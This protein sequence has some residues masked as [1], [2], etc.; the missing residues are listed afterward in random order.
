MHIQPKA[1]GR[2]PYRTV[3]VPVPLVA[4][5][6]ALVTDILY[7]RTSVL[8]W[9]N[10]SAWLLLGGLVFGALAILA[11]I[12]DLLRPN[13]KYYRP[14]WAGALCYAIVL[15]LGLLNSF[16]H[17]GDGWTAVVPG[18]LILSALT[19]IA[20]ILTLWLSAASPLS[21]EWRTLHD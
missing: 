21:H 13:S 7:W 16:V 1:V 8:M 5:V 10:F 9:Q 20:I 18:G 3:L 11:G 14:S 6:F 2:Y 15:L 4:F 17:A 12:V 19:F